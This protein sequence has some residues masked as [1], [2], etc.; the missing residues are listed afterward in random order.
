MA[1]SVYHVALGIILNLTEPDLGCPEIPNLWEKLRAD[2]RPVPERQLQCPE[3]MASQPD[4][5]EWMFLTERDGIR[6]AS[7]FSGR[8]D[9][10]SSSNESDKHKAFKARIARAAEQGGFSVVVEDRAADG[11]RRTD[12]LVK[13]AGDLLVG[14]EV[15]LSY[16]A[17]PTVRKRTRLAR[18]DGISPLWTT[19]DRTRDFINQVPWALT[20]DAPWRHIYEGRELQVRGGV[21]ALEMERCDIRNPRPCPI[22][23]PGKCGGLHGKWVP[24]RA[25]LLDDLVRDTAAGE[26]VPVIIPGKRVHFRWWVRAVD[27]DRYA[28]S[29][30][31]LLTEDLVRRRSSGAEL[32]QTQAPRPVDLEC[33]YG[34][35]SGFR[36][37]PAVDQEDGSEVDASVVTVPAEWESRPLP[38]IR[39]GVC[40]HGTGPCGAMP[41]RLY[42]CGWRCDAHSPGVLRSTGK[43]S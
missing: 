42:P 37:P 8:D 35:D 26:Y 43:L 25:Y 28:D 27:R 11:R 4:C 15:Q 34:Q 1:S 32:T 33:R 18:A 12:V 40:G 10:P 36:S 39:R 30:G 20:D 13:G 7:H 23:Q 6:F 24:K 16:A 21:R 17:L 14:H 5:P 3:C 41:A 31:G 38:P 22:R 2:H 29:A 9:H 19:T